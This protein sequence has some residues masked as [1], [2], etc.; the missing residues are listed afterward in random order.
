MF[1]RAA[2]LIVLALI[3]CNAAPCI[4]A[5]DLRD[6]AAQA[7]ERSV[8][9]YSQKAA[10]H[11]GYVYKY[12][13]DLSKSE[14]EGVTGPDTVWVQPPGTP[15]VGMAFL[16]AYQRTGNEACLK[17]AKAAA[18]CLRQGQL[19]SGGWQADIQFG[20]E[21]RPKHAYR[22]SERSSRRAR[23]NSTFDDDKTQSA[24]RFLIRLDQ[25][26]GFKDEKLHECVMYALDAILKA[27]K[28][29]GGWPQVWTEP[30]DP[31]KFPV[32]KASFPESWPRT[33]PGGDYWHFYTLNDN[34]MADTLDMLW[35]AADVYKDDRYRQS[36]IKGGEF[37]LLAQLPEPQPAWA[38]QYDFDMHPCW[39]RK[40]EPPAVSG[41]E[42]QGVIRAL[43]RL[44]VETGEKKF[45]EPIP[46]ALAYLK[47]SQLPDGRL[48][49]FNELQTN[50]PLYLTR[51][52]ELTYSDS[53]LPTHYGFQVSSKVPQLS[54]EYDRVSKLSAAD[55]AK[56]R[57]K[58]RLSKSGKPGDNEVRQIIAA[59]DDRGA[60]VEDGR[61]SYHK[62]DDT[63]RIIDSRT[64]IKN[65]DALSRYVAD[66]KK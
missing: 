64:F 57:E 54:K 4:D 55:L 62:N 17:A 7:L 31:S 6:S 47:R 49:R 34:T 9:F 59:L 8:A 5:A 1:D 42:S 16:E 61:L 10:K 12:S 27:Q 58:L 45:L 22:T 60:W 39:A 33:Y 25:E 19:K 52:Y 14:G 51:M 50:K 32:M 3:A 40:F 36:A 20:A 41:G 37:F 24:L 48:S 56:E 38:Q 53:D 43:M 26:L 18:E 21:E 29:N 28:P 35:I 63:R 65:L 11:G 44:Y 30:A 46:R 23:D 15:S 13:A 66:G 2:R